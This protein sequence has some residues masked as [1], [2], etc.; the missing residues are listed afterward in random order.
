MIVTD[1]FIFLKVS[2]PST[3]AGMVLKTKSNALTW[4]SNASKSPVWSAARAAWAHSPGWSDYTWTL[5]NIPFR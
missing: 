3:G 5:Q 4:T 1:C 2:S